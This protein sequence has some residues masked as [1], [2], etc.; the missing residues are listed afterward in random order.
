[1]G[2]TLDTGAY[3]HA[4]GSGWTFVGPTDRA[5][6]VHLTLLAEAAT[7]AIQDVACKKLLAAKASRLQGSLRRASPSRSDS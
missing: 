6:D 4:L 5:M 3:R 2:R 7:A 1:M